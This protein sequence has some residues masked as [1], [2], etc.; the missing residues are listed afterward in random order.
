VA[1]QGGVP[2]HG[3]T[4]VLVNVTAVAPSADTFLT[5]YP[6]GIDRPLAANLNVAAG[7]VVPNM[8]V[9][10]VGSDGSIE[11]YNHAG[12]LDVVADVM[13]YFC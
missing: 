5:V 4:A 7:R 2:W 6:S 10:Q 9:A 12:D 11:L 3:A 13:G 1:G 8:V